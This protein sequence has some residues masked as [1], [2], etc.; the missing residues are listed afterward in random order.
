M[1]ILQQRG[2]YR[3]EYE[4]ETFRSN[5]GIPVPQNRHAVAPAVEAAE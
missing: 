3:T 1:P 2:I 5:L 4:G